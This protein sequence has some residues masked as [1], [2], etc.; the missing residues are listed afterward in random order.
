[1]LKNLSISNMAVIASQSLDLAN[2]FTVLTGET[3]AGKSVLIDSVN[4]ILG[5]R[6]DKTLVRHGQKQACCEAEF[7][8][9]NPLVTQMLEEEG[10][11]D[12]ED[13]IILS[14]SLSADG[15]SVCKIN[16]VTVSAAFLKR[17][18]AELINIHGQQDNQKLL[19]KKYHTSVLDK[20]I[21]SKENTKAYDDY[22]N[23]Y[24]EYKAVK[25]KYE[26]AQKSSEETE[27]EIRYLS[28]VADELLKAD[29]KKGEEKELS[30]KYEILS[31][32]MD[33]YN[34]L[35]G[36]YA[37]LYNGEENVYEMLSCAASSV[38]KISAFSDKLKEFKEI[39]SDLSF[40]VKDIASDI[41]DFRDS[42]EPD[43]AALA[44]A[45]E[46]LE[47]IFDLKRKYKKTADELEEYA[48]EVQSRLA[49]LKSD[50]LNL[51]EEKYTEALGNATKSA[52]AIT[53]LR[54]KYKKILEAEIH[55]ALSDLNLSHARFE[56]GITETDLSALGAEKCEFLMC[57]TGKGEM[58]PMEK[59][60]SG[61]ELSRIM[62]AIKYV[63]SD[64]DD[65]PTLIFDEIDTGVSGISA[66]KVAKKL[67][68]LSK[69]KQVICITHLAQIAAMADNHVLI[70]KALAP[71]GSFKTSVTGLSSN[72]RID[73]ISRIMAGDVTGND[74]KSAAKDLLCA[75]EKVKS[76]IV[77]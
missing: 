32:A 26:T 15:R 36:V 67:Y 68:A 8:I 38:S 21:I 60:A 64:C 7:F 50:D 3:G 27:K 47:L 44:A 51:L 31:N 73:E 42:N 30:E 45:D 77:Y 11:F 18:S 49:Q 62:L 39:L 9:K 20:Y 34:S 23:A 57:T 43:D 40:Q 61:G 13:R 29:V 35:S 75:S 24:E 41:V 12:S 16:G 70:S 19:E 28:F 69:K 25:Q 59:I 55:T 6:S 72:G 37:L 14:R 58:R 76:E 1:M 33:I 53:N 56:I 4:M 65:C 48:K 2:G 10:I 63:L 66:A 74:I 71:D 5:N 22:K 46:R 52:K 54:L 17:L